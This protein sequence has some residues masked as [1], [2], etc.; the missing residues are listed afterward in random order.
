MTDRTLLVTL[1]IKLNDLPEEERQNLAD[2]L[3][4]PLHQIRKLSHTSPADIARGIP[5]VLQEFG[6]LPVCAYIE[7]VSVVE[8]IFAPAYV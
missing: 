1:S 4:V 5:Q 8:A 7:D 2:D 6:G 3:Q